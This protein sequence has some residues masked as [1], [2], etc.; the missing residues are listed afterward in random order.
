MGLG[1]HTRQTRELQRQIQYHTER[2]NILKR[3]IIEIIKN[4]RLS[5]KN[6]E[7]EPR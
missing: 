3:Q 5:L 1:F 7:R 4:Q 2:I 6:Y